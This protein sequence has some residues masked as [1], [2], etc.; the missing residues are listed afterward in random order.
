MA[1]A[2]PERPECPD[3]PTIEAI[4]GSLTDP[5]QIVDDPPAPVC[6]FPF[7]DFPPPD[8]PNNDFGCF[9]FTL[10][11]SFGESSEPSFRVNISYPNE[12]ETGKCQPFFEFDV[13]IPP[14]VSFNFATL[15]A[16]IN[17]SSTSPDLTFNV[18]R[19]AGEPCSYEY[20][21]DLQIPSLCADFGF[22]TSSVGINSGLSNPTLDFRL[23]RRTGPTSACAYDVHFNLQLPPLGAGCE[24]RV[25]TTEN[26]T[27]SGTQTIDGVSVSVDEIVLVK[28]QTDGRDNGAYVVKGGSWERTCSFS[29]GTLVSVREGNANGGTIWML[30][31]NDPI[32]IGTTILVFTLAGGAQCCCSARAATTGNVTLSG[33]Q[34]IDGVSLAAGEVVLVKNQTTDSEN[35]VYQVVDGGGWVRTCDIFS[36]MLVSVREGNTHARQVWMLVTNDPITVDTTDLAYEIVRAPG[37]T[38]ARACADA[39]ITLSGLQTIDGVSLAAGERCLVIGQTTASQNGIYI[40]D[41]GTWARAQADAAIVPGMVVSVREGTVH[42]ATIF[43]LL[44]SG[45]IVVDT[46][47]LTFASTLDRLLYSVRATSTANV[48]SLSGSK[49]LDGVACSAGDIVLIREQTTASENGVYRVETS[50]WTKLSPA[51]EGLVAFCREGNTYRRV[52]FIL[53]SDT[54]TWSG[55]ASFLQT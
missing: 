3:V 52:S 55:M 44:T 30:T 13:G 7:F 50:T 17:D 23:V 21:F 34:T 49:F 22:Q 51:K 48:A 28:D 15:K 8:P 32:N 20:E 35:G 54:T 38:T 41:S 36:G 19:K 12:D 25:A 10:A 46:T 39:N 4:E 9:G 5:S 29:G 14:C 18:N 16:E 1:R 42:E 26:I 47:N 27:L 53:E 33:L 43:T 11:S 24:A 45:P 6:E 40:V 37:N 2:F 31:T